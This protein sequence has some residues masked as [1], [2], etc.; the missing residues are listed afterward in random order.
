[1]LGVGPG[2][3]GSTNGVFNIVAYSGIGTTVPNSPWFPPLSGNFMATAF[4]AYFFIHCCNS[5]IIWLPVYTD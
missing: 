2:L 5:L 1:M 3:G 4:F